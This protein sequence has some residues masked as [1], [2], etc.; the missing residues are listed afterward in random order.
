MFILYGILAFGFLF[1][2]GYASLHI[3]KTYFTTADVQFNDEE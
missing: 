1:M 3:Y 2:F